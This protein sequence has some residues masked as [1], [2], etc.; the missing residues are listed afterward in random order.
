MSARPPWREGKASSRGPVRPRTPE[1][2]E[3][4]SG[5]TAPWDTWRTHEALQQPTYPDSHEVGEVTRELR[6]QPPLVFAG[7]VDD[8]R[9]DLGAAGRGEA[10]VLVGG[11]CAE[12]FREATADHLRLK[13]QTL[14][15]MAVVLTYGASLPVVKI[16][17]IAGQYAKPRSSDLETRDGVT[18]PSYRGDAVN[19]YE[20]TERARTPDPHRLLETYQHAASSLNLIRA[21]T[22]GGYADLRL[23]HHWNRGFTANPAYARYES[24]AEEIHRA[25]KFMEAA[26]A[27]FDSLREVDLYSS[28]EALLLE[29]ESAMTRIDSRTG[30][31]YDT[32]GH[33]LW[34]GERT[35]EVDGAHAELLSRVRNPVGVKLGPTTTPEE[36]RRLMDRL[37][38]EGEEGRLTF[39]TRMG[40]GRIREVLPPLLEAA[41][42]DG[43]P[44]TWTTDPMHGNT[45]T[46]STG[47]KTRRFET[48]MDEVRG[49]FEAHDQVGTVPG[50]IHVELTG[51]DVT[52]VLGGSEQLDEASLQ[53]RYET[54][55]DPRLNHQQSLEMAFQVA[56][57]LR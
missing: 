43:R 4:V 51:D 49:F 46:S 1:L 19:S 14:L 52:E 13:I 26:G 45:I 28:H 11:D 3:E 5:A 22:K 55:V 35:R 27:D 39:I 20:F 34:V 12:T 7:E 47:Y 8:L 40:A 36:V 31:P 41:R 18:L 9:A 56:E 29:Y 6:R 15:Q 50:G 33:F 42:S 44:V 24:L 54:L 30:E 2:W 17:R 53:D 21:F 37:N 25:V 48:I 16:G 10:F 32:S 38:P 23:V 57:L